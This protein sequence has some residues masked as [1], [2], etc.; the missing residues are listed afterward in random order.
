MNTSTQSESTVGAVDVSVVMV[1]Y[2][3]EEWTKKALSALPR[4]ATRS[5]TELIVVDN[6]STVLDRDDLL[7]WAGPDA[8]VTFLDENIGFG[9]ACNLAVT[10]STGRTVL[11]LNPDAI[12]DEGAVD[13]LLAFLDENPARGIVGGRITDPQGNL[14]Y[15]SCFGHQ[16]TWSLFCFATGLSTV[17]ARSSVF[18]P[19]GLGKW[20]RDSVREVGIVTGCLLL[21]DRT[22]W[23]RL[24]GFDPR[25][26]MYGEDADLC[27]RAW[28]LGFRPSVTPAA[29]AVHA[30]G[31]SSSSR[32]AKQI[33]LFRGKAS[34]IRKS[35]SGLM[36]VVESA[37]LQ[38]GV[39][40]RGLGERVTR[41]TGGGWLDLWKRRAEWKDGW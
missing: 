3:A 15:G 40:L 18:N 39:C 8:K 5:S 35:H 16:T 12:V 37:F 25:F 13:E 33:L 38:A 30:L 2:N 4:G 36:V 31:A 24:E 23:D 1:T 21:A 29:H 26:F 9:R 22:L 27:K 41:K 10:Q 28:D 32:V 19:E 34:L 7:S 14:D 20:K 11:L 17:F 6:A